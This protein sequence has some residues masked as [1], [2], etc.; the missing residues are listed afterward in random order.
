MAICECQKRFQSSLGQRLTT[1]VLDQ[2]Q[3]TIG[4][5]FSWLYRKL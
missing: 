2:T 5:M 1:L 3:N 4:A